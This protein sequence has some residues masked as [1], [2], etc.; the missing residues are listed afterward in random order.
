MASFSFIAAFVAAAA[1]AVIQGSIGIG[2]SFLVVPVL[3]LVA[4]DLLPTTV[5]L[6]LLP[7]SLAIAV[8]ERFSIDTAGLAWIIGG[9]VAGTALA[10]PA[11]GAFTADEL[12]PIFGGLIVLMVAVTVSRIRVPFTPAT[13]TVTGFLSGLFS[14]LAA[15]G[16]PP[17]GV[18]YS[19]RR[20]S[21]LRS[22]LGLTFA[23]GLG[24]SLLG[25]A[26]GGQISRVQ[27]IGAAKLAPAL[28]LGFAVSRR[29]HGRLDSRLQ[30][31]VLAF[32][33]LVGVLAV[34]Q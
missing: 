31:V 17:L 9:R 20:A 32:A 3:A 30:T 27:L 6:L 34:F 22:T 18:L 24:I 16:G 2:F 25:L 21:E 28:V 19:S 15:L 10:V 11:L 12:R 14:T 7:L 26:L 1:A 23:L 13:M 33:A 4:P 5:L 29:L 8:R